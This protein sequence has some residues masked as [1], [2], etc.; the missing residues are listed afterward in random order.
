MARRRRITVATFNCN[1]GL[2]YQRLHL[3]FRHLDTD[4]YDFTFVDLDEAR[5]INF[6]YTDCI[7][8]CHAWHPNSLNIAERARVHY[9]VPVITDM[10]DLI[11]EVPTHHPQH[12][13]FRGQKVPQIVQASTHMVYATKYLC[14]KL[15]HLNKNFTVIPN[16]I[17]KKVYEAFKP[18]F[19]PYKNCFIAGWTGG[20]SHESDQ[21]HTFLPGLMQFLEETPDAKAYFHVLCPDILLKKFGSQV[22]F[23]PFPA[24]YLDYPAVAAAYPFSVCLVGLVDNE[25]NQAKSDLKLLEMA[26]NG[27]P[28][29]ASPRSDFIQHKDKD[30][31]LYAEEK[32]DLH[33][34][35]YDQL[36][37]AYDHKEEMAQIAERARNYVMGNRLSTTASRQW[38]EVFDLVLG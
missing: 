1:H 30:I 7:V 25:F 5:H 34:S 11:T 36:K 12:V 13:E 15:G 2:V 33:K 28:I 19:K 35:W 14:H 38:Q 8:L 29:I 10:D 23:E 3:P 21:L 37:Y 16:S 26:P 6:L 4:Q 27:I 17:D 18:A 32:S 31:M 22:I 9:K 24:D 20:Q